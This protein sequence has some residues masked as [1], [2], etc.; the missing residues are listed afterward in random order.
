MKQNENGNYIIHLLG[1]NGEPKKNHEVNVHLYH[2]YQGIIK[3][4][5]METDN[6][7]KLDLGKLENIKNIEIE[8]NM[9]HIEQ[10]P[11]YVYKQTI[12][13]LENQEINLPFY[14]N[15]TI[16]LT[17]FNY[18]N[19]TILENLSDLL[20][21]QVTDDKNQLYNLIIPKLSKGD[22]K[23]HLDS[24]EYKI[25]VIKGKV[26]DIK[27]FIICEDGTII[28][29]SIVEKPIALE[30]VSYK[31]NEL[32]IK[33]N[34]NNK[35]TT[36]PR[37]HINCVQYLPKH[38]NTNLLYYYDTSFYKYII[39]NEVKS[40][41][42]NKNENK[43]LN[44][45]I[46]SDEMQY[47]LDRKQYENHLGNSLEK[48]SLLLKPQYIRDTTTEIKEGEKGEEFINKKCKE[49]NYNKSKYYKRHIHDLDYDDDNF[50][51]HDFINVSPYIEENLIPDEN[52]EIIIKKN[53]SEY[54]FLHI[55]C[56][57]NISC[58]ED[59]FYL[60]NGKTSLRDLRAVNE[61]EFDKNYCELR[62]IYP[63]SKKD[64]HHL[65]D[66][67]S[68]K[69]KIF[70]SLENY[71]EFIKIINP[72]L[73][74][75]IKQ[76]EF[77]LNFDNLKLP[78]KLEKMSKYFSHEL[79]IYLYFHHNQ[80]FNEYIYPILKYK[81]EKTFIDYFLLNDKQKISE[82][83]KKQKIEGLYTFEKCLL[84]YSIR[85]TNKQLANRL[86]R[87]IRSEC[88]REDYKEI[89]KLF[90]IALNLKSLKEEEEV[91]RIRK[92]CYMDMD[93]DRGRD[94]DDEVFKCKKKKKNV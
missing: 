75:D 70:D 6:E 9:F 7:G 53:F 21:I 91:E 63:L 43:Y 85:E 15:K 69:Y 58:S 77:L 14:G 62:K 65:K 35:S 86:S 16:H 84:I 76:F 74:N 10:N 17:K 8:N 57:D 31:N 36:R 55:I 44:N 68:I 11:K 4:I 45:K 49:K 2:K 81:S 71:V 33:L 39:S 83:V 3:P 56:F 51:V 60:N 38:F 27:D 34:K 37:I 13:I 42:M 23:L 59:Y 48:P 32:K 61:L 5:L 28:S 41:N 87:K 90:N 52:G 73:E 92:E 88:P 29:N 89:K 40:F 72:S 25:N 1:K 47:I 67:T 80:F 46:L 26:M 94:I 22:Y 79:N 50:T 82:Y 18:Y 30:N 66:I 64:K 19:E 20:K 78:E 12:I 54:S 93:M 24:E